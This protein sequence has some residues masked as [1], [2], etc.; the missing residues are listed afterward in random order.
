MATFYQFIHS[1]NGLKLQMTEQAL[2]STKN[3]QNTNLNEW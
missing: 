1:I 2:L 3:L